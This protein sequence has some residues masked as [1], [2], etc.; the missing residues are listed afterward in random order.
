[1]PRPAAEAVWEAVVDKRSPWRIRDEA[2]AAAPHRLKEAL[3]ELI[4]VPAEEVTMTLH[5][6][7]RA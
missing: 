7:V 6:A 1:M 4:G 2:F 5:S 3:G